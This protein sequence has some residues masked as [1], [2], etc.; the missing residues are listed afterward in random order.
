M[1]NSTG[2]SRCGGTGEIVSPGSEWPKECPDCTGTSSAFSP[3]AGALGKPE[4]ETTE[5]V[6]GYFAEQDE[7]RDA[8]VSPPPYMTR[9]ELHTRMLEQ[10]D[11]VA[12]TMTAFGEVIGK[13][14]DAV[15]ETTKA[16]NLIEKAFDGLGPILAEIQEEDEDEEACGATD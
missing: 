12:G 15:R 2:C 4:E 14:G 5:L 11:R 8:E 7:H 16:M 9:D 1:T 10:W 13:L 3:G 6:D